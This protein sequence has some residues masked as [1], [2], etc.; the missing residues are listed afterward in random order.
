MGE[1]AGG[2]RSSV[3]L[4]THLAL[5]A[6]EPRSPGCRSPDHMPSPSGAA[7]IFVFIVPEAGNRTL[8]AK[9]MVESTSVCPSPGASWRP[10][11]KPA[12]LWRP[13][14]EVAL[15]PPPQ[16]PGPCRQALGR[17]RGLKP[18]LL[19]ARG[20]AALPLFLIPLR[21]QEAAHLAAALLATMPG[22]NNSPPPPLPSSVRALRAHTLALALGLGLRIVM[23]WKEI[24]LGMSRSI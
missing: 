24:R 15:P 2:L 9:R 11:F 8:G 19:A 17:E 6:S 14:S 13:R 10:R 12:H 21:V 3:H 16:I 1:L 7:F 20:L 22:E 4:G 23:S 18:L 5:G